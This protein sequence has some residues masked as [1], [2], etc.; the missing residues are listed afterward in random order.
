MTAITEAEVDRFND[1]LAKRVQAKVGAN[2]A[3]A[4]AEIY[5]MLVVKAQDGDK[6]AIAAIRKALVHLERAS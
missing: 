2:A 4:V 3:T 1:L 5:A 6:D